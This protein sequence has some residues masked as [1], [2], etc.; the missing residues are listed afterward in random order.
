M[1]ESSDSYWF[2]SNFFLNNYIRNRCT[3]YSINLQ[4]HIFTSNHDQPHQIRTK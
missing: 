1:C 4:P 3:E 2:T